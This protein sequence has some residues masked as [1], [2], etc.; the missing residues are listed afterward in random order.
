MAEQSG[1]GLVGVLLGALLVVGI[2][3]GVLYATGNLGGQ[4]STATLKVEVPKAK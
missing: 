1:S 3:V 4:S 2:G